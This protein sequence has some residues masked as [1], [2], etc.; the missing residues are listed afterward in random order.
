MVERARGRKIL[1]CRRLAR[2]PASPHPRIPAGVEGGEAAGPDI[3][4]DTGGVASNPKQ[5]HVRPHERRWKEGR[6]TQSVAEG[7]HRPRL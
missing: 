4:E 1:S 7:L 5:A 6:D 2:L 3:A